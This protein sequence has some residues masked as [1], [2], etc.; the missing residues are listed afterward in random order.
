MNESLIEGVAFVDSWLSKA[1]FNDA[2]GV[3]VGA[4]HEGKDIFKKAYGKADVENDEVMSTEHRFQI[5]SQSKVFTATAIMQLLEKSVLDPSVPVAQ[6]ISE[7]GNATDARFNDVTIE[8]LLT[9]S[10]GLSRDGAEADFW[11][12]KAPFP[13]ENTLL[14]DVV[15]NTL[16]SDPGSRLKYSNVGYGLLGIIVERSTGMSYE[17]Y[18]QR[19]ILA[20]LHLG[21][22]SVGGRP[23]GVPVSR[24]Y[25]NPA[26][27]RRLL[28]DVETR[29]LAPATGLYSTINDLLVFYQQFLDESNASPVLSSDSISDMITSY[30]EMP[31]S[32]N[33]EYGLGIDIGM[34]NG[35][36]VIGHGGGYPGQKSGTIVDAENSIVV[37]AFANDIDA[38]P[39][40]RSMDIAR[41]F[42]YF[43]K[44]GGVPR[45]DR[46]HFNTT[47]SSIWQETRIQTVGDTVVAVS[48]QSKDPFADGN[49]EV[50]T[51]IDDRTLRITQASGFGHLGEIVSFPE[52]DNG[53]V[54][55]GGRRLNKKS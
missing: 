14:S 48:A 27:N 1:H 43:L 3:I 52:D 16:L 5:A 2:P 10:A 34:D 26:R 15:K 33:V 45:P 38:D 53:T 23:S 17:S 47:L 54:I 6:Y 36:R 13:S 11:E 31:R 24:G 12:L 21:Q 39:F 25:D 49:L 4:T 29:A 51:P 37:S 30:G 28:E 18:V 44:N 19:H 42:R 55:Y 40:L 22:T 41:V 7:L 46:Q 35:T 50:L 9:H 8:Q 20:P 32:G